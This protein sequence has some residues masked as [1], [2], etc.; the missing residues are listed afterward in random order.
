[1]LLEGCQIKLGFVKIDNLP[2]EVVVAGLSSGGRRRLPRWRVAGR[3]TSV[4]MVARWRED[5]LR[6]CGSEAKANYGGGDEPSPAPELRKEGGEGGRW[7]KEW[8]R[9]QRTVSGRLGVKQWRRKH[10]ESSRSDLANLRFSPGICMYLQIIP[11]QLTFLTNRCHHEKVSRHIHLYVYGV[12]R[13][14][15]FCHLCASLTLTC[16]QSKENIK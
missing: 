6:R 13:E 8:K 4:V 9:K 3:G 11:R 5:G 7:E 14:P 1:M 16:E 12:V 10:S 15:R 2:R